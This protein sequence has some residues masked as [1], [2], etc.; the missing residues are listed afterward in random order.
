MCFVFVKVFLWTLCFDHL[1]LQTTVAFKT[2][3]Q[4]KLRVC[5]SIIHFH[6]RQIKTTCRVCVPLQ[7]N[8]MSTIFW[9]EL[10]PH[11]PY[12]KTCQLLFFLLSKSHAWDKE[13]MQV[14]CVTELLG[15]HQKLH[16]WEKVS[17]CEMWPGVYRWVYNNLKRTIKLYLIEPE[18]ELC[19][20][21]TFYMEWIWE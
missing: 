2:K 15:K 11:I 20:W 14:I 12:L 19:I 13:D 3:L 17:A 7:S 5:T 4:K 1:Y 9:D 6:A 10:Y 16:M 8:L 21:E 18:M